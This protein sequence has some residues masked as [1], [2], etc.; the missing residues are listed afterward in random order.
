MEE[1]TIFSVSVEAVFFNLVLFCNS[2]CASLDIWSRCYFPLCTKFSAWYNHMFTLKLFEVMSAHTNYN[3]WFTSTSHTFPAVF[4]KKKILH[5]VNSAPCHSVLCSE[6][7]FP[8]T[9]KW[10]FLNTQLL[11]N[12]ELLLPPSW[13]SMEGK[14]QLQGQD[15]KF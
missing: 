3:P 8:N 1:N 11:M 9:K 6:M 12:L 2:S 13:G 14:K 15:L 7:S 10:C 5:V 4:Q